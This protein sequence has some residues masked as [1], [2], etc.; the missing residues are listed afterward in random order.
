MTVRISRVGADVLVT[1]TSDKAARVVR[2][3]AEVI[4]SPNTATGPASPALPAGRGATYTIM[5]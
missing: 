1:D 4:A 2:M 3:Y 5:S